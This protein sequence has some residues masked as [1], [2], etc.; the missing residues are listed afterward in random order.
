MGFGEARGGGRGL[1]WQDLAAVVAKMLATLM[2]LK[3]VSAAGGGRG[4]G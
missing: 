2:H 4:E 1:V 3:G